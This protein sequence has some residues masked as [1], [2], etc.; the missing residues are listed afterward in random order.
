M[1]MKM[2]FAFVTGLVLLTSEEIYA[3][4]H[5]AQEF[6]LCKTACEKKDYNFS[7]ESKMGCVTTCSNS[8]LGCDVAQLM[9]QVARDAS[10]SILTGIE[11]LLWTLVTPRNCGPDKNSRCER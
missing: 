8:Q 11:D 6:N 9:P 7:N 3:Q 4:G 2:I 10:N 5:C 1:T